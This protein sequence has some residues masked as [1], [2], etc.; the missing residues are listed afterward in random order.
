MTITTPDD[1]R[2]ARS[3]LGMSAA[4]LAR[5]LRMGANADRTV[6]RWESGQI[7]ISGPAAVAIEAMLA[8]YRP[9]E[10]S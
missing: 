5:A 4:A 2:Q 7:R 10:P 6:R 1:I 3:R 8:G 9:G